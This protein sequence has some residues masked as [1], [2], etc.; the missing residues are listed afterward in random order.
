MTALTPKS[1]SAL[2]RILS[3]HNITYIKTPDLELHMGPA[4]APVVS[5]KEE[6]KQP[7]EEIK[8]LLTLNDAD[9][10]DKMFPESP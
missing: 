9:I 10:L 7:I 1:L 6:Y 3:K 2:A 5:A 4:P 8:S